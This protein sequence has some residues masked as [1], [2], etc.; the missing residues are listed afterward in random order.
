[1]EIANALKSLLGEN[2]VLTAPQDRAA[3]EQ[4]W[5]KLSAHPALAVVLPQSVEQVA[6]IV[7]FCAAKDIK[8]VPQGGNTGLAGGGVPSPGGNQ[9]ILSLKR[10]R[11]LR[12]LNPI[13]NTITVEAGLTLL[14]VQQAAAEAKKFF[15]VSLAAEGTAEIGG[16]IST[17][18][19][20]VQVLSYGTTRAQ[21]LGL[22]VVLA[23]GKIW[24]GLRAL[25]K[26]N[27]GLD[28]KQVFIGAEGTLGIVTAACLKLYPA[29]VARAT[30]LVGV[31]SVAGALELFQ[32]LREA[33]GVSLTLCEY[34]A[35][36]TMILAAAHTAAGRPPFPAAAYLLAELSTPNPA[37]NVAAT[38]ESVLEKALAGGLASDALIAQS[39]RERRDFLALREAAPE[40]EMREGGAVKHD[41]S[42][43]LHAMPEMVAA[44]QK[45]VAEKYPDCRLNVYGHLGDG[46]LHINVMAP[47][48]KTVADIKDRY[49]AITLDV[50]S[51]A[52]GMDGSFTAEHGV[53]QMRL[54][55]MLAHK[56]R[57]ELELMRAIKQALDP[58]GLFNP[59]KLLPE[60]HG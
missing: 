5:R 22:E 28:L 7:E 17:N 42:V 58:A 43:P 52:A 47:P 1:M 26:D 50:E 9:L 35:G 48:G 29:P 25:R 11:K 12:G 44:T 34:L 10:L 38:L 19:G 56:S 16:V 49:D 8:I 54:S 37:E 46:N 51:L 32:A 21:V 31:A 39:E 60:D 41:I 57:T 40:S 33:A 55:G 14:E 13:G 24:N 4:D 36:P 27:A 45:L 53:G 20:G 15:P 2:A 23:S 18:A 6:A 30:A 3:Y 59:G